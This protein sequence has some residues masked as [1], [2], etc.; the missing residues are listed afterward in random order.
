MHAEREARAL[1]AAVAALAR[2][3]HGV[4]AR[5][6]L[7]EIGLGRGAIEHRV[8]V[9]SL[10]PLHRGVY[11][12]GHSALKR[13]AWWLAAVLAAGPGAALSYRSAAEFWGLRQT[14]RARIEV[15]APGNRRSTERLEVHCVDMEADELTLED[16]IRV[17]TPARTLLDLAAVVTPAQL[18]HAFDEAE[19]RRL[20]SPLSLDALLARYPRR[21]GSRA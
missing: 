13:E 5:S 1:D 8:A 7:T 3:Q 15:S 11:A 20:T 19:Y 9:E 12:V 10:Q 2:R 4:V 18:E 14:S 6:Q 21:R 16:G 17:T